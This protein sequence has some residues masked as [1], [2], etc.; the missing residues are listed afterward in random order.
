MDLAHYSKAIVATVMG[1][2]VII[3]AWTGWKSQFISEEVVLSII[4][5]ATP[6]LVYL[7]P[8]RPPS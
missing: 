4:A 7:I 6:L 5:V 1:A 3:E 8:N 2:L